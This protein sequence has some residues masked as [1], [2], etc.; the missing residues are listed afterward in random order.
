MSRLLGAVARRPAGE[1]IEQRPGRIEGHARCARRPSWLATGLAGGD[2]IDGAEPVALAVV[3]DDGRRGA[4]LVDGDGDDHAGEEVLVELPRG[5]LDVERAV[6][7][8][9]AADARGERD[10][11][12]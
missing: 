11:E 6:A 2:G 4:G 12:R 8:D 10:R 7:A 3:L 1:S 5:A 9:A